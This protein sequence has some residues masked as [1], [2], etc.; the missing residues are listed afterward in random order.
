MKIIPFACAQNKVAIAG[1]FAAQAAFHI[2]PFKPL[3]IALVCTQDP[4]KKDM[5][6]KAEKITRQRV[7]RLGGTLHA[8]HCADQ[9]AAIAAELQASSADLILIHGASAI[10][11]EHDIIPSAIAQIGGRLIHFGMP[12]DPGNLLLLAEYQGKPVVGLPGCA[13]SPARNGFDLVLERLVCGLAVSKDDIMNMGIGG[14][15]FG[16]DIEKERYG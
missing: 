13:R 7:E 16:A 5:S 1:D 12:T 6:A 8:T 15:M 2:E 3:N 4:D 14:L 9:S 11:D 10:M